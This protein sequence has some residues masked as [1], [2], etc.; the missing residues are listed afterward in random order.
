M[1]NCILRNVHKQGAGNGIRAGKE[2]GDRVRV[3]RGRKKGTC[4]ITDVRTYGQRNME[5][6]I[7]FY[8]IRLR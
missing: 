3:C 5:V 6:E 8:I 2:K 4:Y 1:Q 7:S